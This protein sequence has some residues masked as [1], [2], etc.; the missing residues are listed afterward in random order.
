MP[1]TVGGG[2][3]AFTHTNGKHC[4]VLQVVAPST[5][6][7]WMA[8]IGWVRSEAGRWHGAECCCPAAGQTSQSWSP[9]AALARDHLM[10]GR[11]RQWQPVTSPTH[12]P[13]APTCQPD[14]D[15]ASIASGAVLAVEQY[16]A[17]RKQSDGSTA[18]EQIS[19]VYSTQVSSAHAVAAGQLDGVSGCMLAAGPLS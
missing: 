5:S 14:A 15:K 10:K 2:I 17:R 19:C 8:V 6:G 7:G 18:I 11:H 12:P 13:T 9:C 4:S 1:I 3:S 16:L